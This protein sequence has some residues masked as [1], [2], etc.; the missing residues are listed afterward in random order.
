[1]RRRVLMRT[2]SLASAFASPK[3]AMMMK[4]MM[5]TEKDDE[6][7]DEEESRSRV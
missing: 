1:M 6:K 2:C 5:E 4:M 3:H 7:D